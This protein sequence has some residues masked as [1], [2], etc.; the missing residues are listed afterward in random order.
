[1]SEARPAPPPKRGTVYALDELPAAVAGAIDAARY[2]LDE[3]AAA[4]AALP[5]R[6]R[7][8]S[9]AA[10]SRAAKVSGPGVLALQL[11]ILRALT[12]ADF[13]GPLYRVN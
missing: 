11:D 10:V 9:R 12:G 13:T 1:M 4:V 8:P 7:T 5:T 6:A 2:T 3:T